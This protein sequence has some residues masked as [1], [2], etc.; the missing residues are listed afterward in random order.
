VT[1][2]LALPLD[3]AERP[4]GPSL[5]GLALAPRPLLVGTVGAGPSSGVLGGPEART[6]DLTWV[7]RD[8]ASRDR[9]KG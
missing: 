6:G 3:A 7:E 8:A 5:L 2:R 1:G 4:L 9:R